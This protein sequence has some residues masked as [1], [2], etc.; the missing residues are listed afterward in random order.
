MVAAYG[1]GGASDMATRTLA[2]TAPTYLQQGVLVVNKAG[3]GG[4]VG[5]TY[6]FKSRPDG[7]TLLL[8]RVATHA[9]SPAIKNLPY[10]P[11]DFTI[12][13]LLEKNPFVCAT[14]VEKP[15]KSLKDLLDA[16]KANP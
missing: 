7:Y 6:A 16:I 15:Y 12:L 5:S 4:T 11:M 14:N 10:K 13:G 1:P 8:A 3:A 2:A 9:V